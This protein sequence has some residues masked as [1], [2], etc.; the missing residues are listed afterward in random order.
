MGVVAD[1][2]KG[3]LRDEYDVERVA[4]LALVALG[5]ITREGFSE[6]GRI[7]P[8]AFLRGHGESIVTK[9]D[10]AVAQARVRAWGS[11]HAT[12]VGPEK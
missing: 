1:R 3:G 12:G 7:D 4:D 6:Q 8:Q 11:S 9:G 10:A 5:A 2:N